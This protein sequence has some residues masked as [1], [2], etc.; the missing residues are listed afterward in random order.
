MSK[1]D[2]EDRDD[3][4]SQNFAFPKQRKEPLE[5]ASHVRSAIARFNQ[6]EEFVIGGYIPEGDT[7]SRLFVG[8]DDLRFVKKLKNGFTQFTKQEVM[9]AIRRLRVKRCPFVNPEEIEDEDR[10]E[11]VWVRPVRRVEVEFV[12]WT[13]GGRL[14][15]ASF[16]RQSRHQKRRAPRHR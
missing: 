10:A 16:R 1:L 2:Q 11:A 15:H 3:L 7:F 6:V 14:R 9:N 12:E 4:S 13:E 8:T 5:D